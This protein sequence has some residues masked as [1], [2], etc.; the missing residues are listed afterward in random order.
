M[1]INPYFT[2]QN[3]HRS[4]KHSMNF[5]IFFFFYLGPLKKSMQK[6]IAALRPIPILKGGVTSGLSPIN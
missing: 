3:T 5:F 4:A 1:L 2:L 6:K